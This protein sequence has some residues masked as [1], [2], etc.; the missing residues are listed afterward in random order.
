MRV[1]SETGDPQLTFLEL[2]DM[3][4]A[5]SPDAPVKWKARA[6]FCVFDFDEVRHTF[7]NNCCQ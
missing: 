7:G 3:Y 6:C 1:F 2:L 5:L 4:S